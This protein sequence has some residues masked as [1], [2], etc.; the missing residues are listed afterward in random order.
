MTMLILGLLYGPILCHS[1]RFLAMHPIGHIHR[2]AN[3]M[4]NTVKTMMKTKKNTAKKMTKK[5]EEKETFST[6]FKPRCALFPLSNL[7]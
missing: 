7:R 2:I 1:N 4:V 3:T 5:A 6:E